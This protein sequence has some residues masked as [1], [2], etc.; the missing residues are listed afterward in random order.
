MWANAVRSEYTIVQIALGTLVILLALFF[1]RQGN[2]R[3]FNIL[4]LVGLIGLIGGLMA[5]DLIGF[6][7]GL[8]LFVGWFLV[9]GFMAYSERSRVRDR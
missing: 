3:K 4:F 2:T 5:S 1:R 7:V 6:W 8:M 9:A